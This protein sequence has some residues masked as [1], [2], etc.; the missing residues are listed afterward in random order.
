MK[1]LVHYTFHLGIF[2]YCLSKNFSESKIKHFTHKIDHKIL[3]RRNF[4]D[5][6]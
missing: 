5:F 3:A 1:Y 6:L 2:A 4:S